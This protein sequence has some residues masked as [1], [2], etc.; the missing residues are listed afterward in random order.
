MLSRVTNFITYRASVGKDSLSSWLLTSILKLRYAEYLLPTARALVPLN[1]LI[2]SL[3]SYYPHVRDEQIEVQEAKG[4]AQG[5][6]DGAQSAG[7]Q[8]CVVWLQSSHFSSLT[9]TLK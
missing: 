6:L 3:L 5:L 8:P 2:W 7:T 9:E 1:N 4:V